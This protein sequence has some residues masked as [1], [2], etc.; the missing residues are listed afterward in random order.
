MLE[1]DHRECPSQVRDESGPR[2]NNA[3]LRDRKGDGLLI[4][5]NRIQT[6]CNAIQTL[7]Q[8][9]SNNYSSAAGSG[10]FSV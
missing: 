7:L 8:L 5:C 1:L 10:G 9:N 2:G 4:H 3:E 6:C